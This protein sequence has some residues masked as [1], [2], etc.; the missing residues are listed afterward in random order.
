MSRDLC[1]KHGILPRTW[2]CASRDWDKNTTN[3]DNWQM[4]S[5]PE[6]QSTFGRCLD[7]AS[8]PMQHE[9]NRC[10]IL[11]SKYGVFSYACRDNQGLQGPGK[12]V[13]MVVLSRQCMGFLEIRFR[14]KPRN[15]VRGGAVRRSKNVEIDHSCI[16]IFP[17]LRHTRVSQKPSSVV[18]LSTGS[19]FQ[20]IE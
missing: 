7:R 12:V 2:S 14:G 11:G 10:L 8:V 3:D 4:R 1:H 9:G 18:I 17:F 16:K 15:M 19:A 5:N 20:N 6:K 13:G